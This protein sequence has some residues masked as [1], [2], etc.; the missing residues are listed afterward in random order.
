MITVRKIKLIIVGDKEEINYRYKYLRDSM[1]SQYKALNLV[2]GYI[3][4]HY[5]NNEDLKEFNKWLKDLR[6]SSIDF[7]DI[8][9]GKGIDTK[10]IVLN[11]VKKHFKADMKNGILSGE[12]CF[13]N[14]KRNYPLMTCGRHLKF[15]YENDDIVI[16]WVNKT[17]FKVIL[18]Q[19]NETELRHTLHKVINEE[20]KVCDST[21]QIDNKEIILN[22]TIDI[23]VNKN[24]ELSDDKVCGVDL[25]LSI[26]AVCA[27]NF[28]A[29]EK[30]YIGNIDD[31]LRVR[32]KIQAKRRRLQQ[33]LKT[34]N[35]GKGRNKKLKSMDNF[36]DYERNF[37]K[38]Y[39]HMVSKEIIK[40][41]IKNK[42]KYINLEELTK[43]GFKDTVLRNW[44][45]YEL[46]K[47]IE[48]KAE[49]VGITVRYVDPAYTSQKCSNCGNLE[50]GQRISQ[51]EFKCKKCGYKANADFNGARNISMKEVVKTGKKE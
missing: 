9:F 47:Q 25:G 24:I 33:Q 22:L 5:L 27:V 48:Y 14:Y 20:Y 28:S 36:R 10:S 44:S 39:N 49:R 16:N 12:R 7:K 51:A 31:F 43:D 34:S 23:P 19:K 41:A 1:Y 37:V 42:C 35:G 26:P 8:T 13:R 29:F 11:T 6:S 2:Y 4:M 32:T 50:E 15:S 21:I 17:K 40:F 46:Q 3:G 38:T 30:K 45:Y 18:G